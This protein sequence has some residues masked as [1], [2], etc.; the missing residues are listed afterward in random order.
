MKE[1]SLIGIMKTNRHLFVLS[2]DTKERTAYLK[3]LEQAHPVRYNSSELVAI[4]LD[5]PGIIDY[6]ILEPNPDDKILKTIAKEY[7]NLSIVINLLRKLKEDDMETVLGDNLGFLIS[8][9][10]RLYLNKDYPNIK[11]LDEMIHELLVS[12]QF[13]QE[14][15][16]SYISGV[17]NYI[18]DKI[19]KIPSVDPLEVIN[20]TKRMLKSDSCFVVIANCQQ[21]LSAVSKEALNS[22]VNVITNRDLSMRIVTEDKWQ[23]YT[24]LDGYPVSKTSYDIIEL[25][26]ATVKESIKTRTKTK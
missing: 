7:L 4:Y 5:I 22:K 11:T 8:P 20:Y 9:M 3:S 21:E 16:L 13:Y 2:P 6:E 23:N 10:N 14:Y 26:E 18:T 24:C 25:D 17:P 15:Y 19:I 12:R 1:N